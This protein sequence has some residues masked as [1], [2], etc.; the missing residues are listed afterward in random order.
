[1]TS[2]GLA[3]LFQ[4]IESFLGKKSEQTFTL[5]GYVENYQWNSRYTYFDLCDKRYRMRCYAPQNAK[6]LNIY[7]KDRMLVELT[8]NVGLYKKDARLQFVIEKIKQT[9]ATPNIIEMNEQLLKGFEKKYQNYLINLNGVVTKIRE[10]QAT[11]EFSI[12][13]ED[14]AIRCLVSKVACKYPI[15]ENQEIEVI[16]QLAILLESGRIQLNT[17]EVKIPQLTMEQLFHEQLKHLKSKALWPKMKHPIPS[18]ITKIG[19]VTGENTQAYQDFTHIY[20]REGGTA[21]IV[22]QQARMQGDNAPSD[23]VKAVNTLSQQQKVDVI[24]ITR[25]GGHSKN[26]V[27]FNDPKIAEVICYSRIPVITAIG[28][29]SDYFLADL[30]ADYRASTPTDAAYTLVKKSALV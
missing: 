29:E 27:A 18:K 3:S 30:V 15:E 11:L 23:I 1:M 2:L 4:N 19:L 21:E 24:V 10:K 28:H 25:G 7:L 26:L 5:I 8:G 12:I 17:Q 14:L 22:H 16:G 20:K 6:Q 13:Q 9:E